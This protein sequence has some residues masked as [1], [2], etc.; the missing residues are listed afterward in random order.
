MPDPLIYQVA[1]RLRKQLLDYE[2]AGAR[3]LIRYYGTAWQGIKA[4]LDQLTAEMAQ[5]QALG[6]TLDPAWLLQQ[7]RLTSLQ[8][9]V[10]TEMAAFA[11]FADSQITSEQAEAV[12]MA[13]EHSRLLAEAG[14]GE[15]PPGIVG[16]WDVLPVEASHDLIG[17]LQNGS[18]LNTLLDELPGETGREVA[19]ALMRGL[20][21]G[22][23]P[24]T[25]ALLASQ[26]GGIGL[27]RALKIART[28]M[29]RSY[30]EATRRSYERNGDIVK[31]WTWHSALDKRTCAACWAMHGTIHPLDERMAEHINGRCAMIPITKTWKE[32]GYTGVRETQARI[33]EGEEVFRRQPKEVQ[34]QVLGKGHYQL[35]KERGI[36]LR[37]MVG[38]RH[39]TE[40]GDSVYIRPLSDFA[41]VGNAN[42]K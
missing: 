31:G 26:A 2:R 5:A 28:E 12:R 13:V 29:L 16:R 22:Q 30:R 25:V 4:K 11:R 40:W 41:E 7:A 19:D 33:P 32:L 9:Q 8:V 37:D 15:T 36:S 17:F 38:V 21:M 3:E 35:W 14:M 6:Q 24:R 1:A 42:I 34:E 39:S 23:S 18:P 27:V 20:M 10:E